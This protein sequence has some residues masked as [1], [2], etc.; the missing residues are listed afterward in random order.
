MMIVFL[1]KGGILVGIAQIRKT[2]H[3]L[4]KTT[5]SNVLINLIQGLTRGR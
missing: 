1:K 3:S 2:A 5:R 4:K